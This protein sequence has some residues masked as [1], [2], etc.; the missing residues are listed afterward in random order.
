MAYTGD[1]LRT[2]AVILLC[3]Y[4]ALAQAGDDLLIAR[5]NGLW[6]WE[7]TGPEGRVRKKFLNQEVLRLDENGA[8]VAVS[9]QPFQEGK[10]VR[11][12]ESAR[13]D[14][15][16]ACSSAFLDCKADGGGAFSALLGLVINGAK[17]AA[18]ARNSYRCTASRD[19]VLEAANQ[20]GLM[21]NL[22]PNNAERRG[23]SSTKGKTDPNGSVYDPT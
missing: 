7:S 23:G 6:T 5:V 18:D 12:S 22:A 4:S 3:A 17:G 15:R 20:V 13:H 2:A 1:R 10:T 19:A 8:V 11:C 21:E 9:L 14:P 16:N